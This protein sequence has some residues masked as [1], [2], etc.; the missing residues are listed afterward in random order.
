MAAPTSVANATATMIRR[1]SA[2]GSASGAIWPSTMARP[3]TPTGTASQAS[4]NARSIG[5]AASAIREKRTWNGI[6]PSR[7]PTARVT[8]SA[9][10]PRTA[11]APAT[12]EASAP[13][14][15]APSVSA[16]FS[17]RDRNHGEQHGSNDQR[18]AQLSGRRGHG[19]PAP[20]RR[21]GHQR[22]Q[23]GARGRRCPD[24][25]VRGRERDHAARQRGEGG[26]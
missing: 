20:R 12:V 15:E 16:A 21:D 26:R 25:E 24:C 1:S 9:P 11:L 23:S 19:A 14:I 6:A 3:T 18:E 17:G 22:R 2:N 8:A 4:S 5:V 10:R 7:A 13:A